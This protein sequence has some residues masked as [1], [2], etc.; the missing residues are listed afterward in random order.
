MDFANLDINKK[1]ILS[2]QN[3]IIKEIALLKQKKYRDKNNVYCLE[4][5][6]L[7]EECLK[8]KCRVKTVIYTKEVLKKRRLQDALYTFGKKFLKNNPNSAN[9]FDFFNIDKIP[10]LEVS[11]EVYNKISDTEEPQGVMVIVEKFEYSLDRL[12]S[13]NKSDHFIAVLDNIQDPGNVGTIIRTAD[14]AGCSA[15][16]MLQGTADLF[17][18]KTV[19]S[20]MGS[21]FHLP[22]I[23]GIES[24]NLIKYLKENNV[25]LYA[26]ALDSNN[27]YTNM[28]FTK[29]LAIAFGNEAN[30]LSENILKNADKNVCIPIH[31]QAE[32]LNVSVAAGIILYEIAKI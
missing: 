3:P 6:R 14:A 1:I 30:G 23:Q 28:K 19:R 5:I 2:V 20:S 17:N 26:T 12:F 4:G 29:P 10:F 11:P 7:I 21:L 9:Y 22:I 13:K 32:S 16:I 24:Q 31:G 27:N 18:P 15:V 8:S 25:A